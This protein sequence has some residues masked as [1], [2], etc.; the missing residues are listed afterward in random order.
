MTVATARDLVRVMRTA[1]PLFAQIVAAFGCDCL[2]GFAIT[3]K[4]VQGKRTDQPA[5]VFYVNRK[6]SLRNLPVQN[7]IP[8]QINIPWEYTEDGVLEV[9]T[10]V[11]VARFQA[12]KN[13]ARVRPCP[14]GFSIGHP[15]I[16][17]GTFGCLVK[18]LQAPGVP[19]ILSNNHVLA[20]TNAA[21]IG[22]PI[23]QPGTSDGGADP[24]DWIADLTQFY[25]IDF[26]SGAANRIDAAIATPRDPWAN[27]VV[28]AIHDI[29]PGIPTA[30]RHIGVGDLDERLQKKGRTTGHTWGYVDSVMATVQVKYGLFQKATFVDQIIVSNPLSQPDFSAGGDS[31]SAVLDVDNRLVGLLFAGSPSDPNAGTQATTIVNPIRFVFNLLGLDTW[32]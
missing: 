22:D 20:D 1:K 23:I 9:V 30:T 7:R 28:H 11:Q 29:G 15:D 21:A 26:T 27:Y 16:T 25:P 12:H 10:D 4:Q 8:K 3:L 18:Y 13:V 2:N 32:P 6:L 31:G 17:A 14:G 19:V 24:A 5:I